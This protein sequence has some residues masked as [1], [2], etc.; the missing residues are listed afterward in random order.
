M[1]AKVIESLENTRCFKSVSR[2]IDGVE[3]DA[4]IILDIRNFNVVLQPK[5]EAAVGISA[6]FASRGKLMG[7]QAF[8]EKV[9]LANP[10]A[11]GAVAALD[12]AFGKGVKALSAWA[13]QMA[14]EMPPPVAQDEIEPPP[15]PPSPPPPPAPSQ[16][17]KP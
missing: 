17:K 4:Q 11:T 12:A 14:A 9:A 2:P 10:D 7:A 1:Q 16:G 3:P 8:R 5:A 15:A 6:K 13:V